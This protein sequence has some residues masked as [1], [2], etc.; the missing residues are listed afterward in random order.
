M[1]K[2]GGVDELKFSETFGVLGVYLLPDLFK[3]RS[4][5]HE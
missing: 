2:Q 5:T 4:V 3:V 1:H